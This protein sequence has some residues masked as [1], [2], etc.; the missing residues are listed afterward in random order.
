MFERSTM[1]PD[2]PTKPSVIVVV[3][4]R[5]EYVVLLQQRRK[6]LADLSPDIQEG[7][8]YQSDPEEAKGGLLPGVTRP[9]HKTVQLVMAAL[10]QT[11]LQ[12][13]FPLH[14]YIVDFFHLVSI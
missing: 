14:G 1:L 5:N 10:R 12:T 4:L 13:N 3:I 9:H 8:H 2:D 6:A 7:N 11:S